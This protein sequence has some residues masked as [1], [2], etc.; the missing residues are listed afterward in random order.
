MMELR[1]HML[2]DFPKIVK[3]RIVGNCWN[4]ES[5][6]G[7]PDPKVP[8]SLCPRVPLLPRSLCFIP[9]MLLQIWVSVLSGGNVC[10]WASL[11][12]T[13]QVGPLN[14][15]ESWPNHP[16]LRQWLNQGV[17]KF[18]IPLFQWLPILWFLGEPTPSRPPAC[19]QSFSETLGL[20]GPLGFRFPSRSK[21]PPSSLCNHH[22]CR[23]SNEHSRLSAF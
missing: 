3:L 20:S 9:L 5:K 18:R 16:W 8:I 12:P 13:A 7:L 21:R 6:L 22:C 23:R 19:V 15:P 1:I 2:S 14:N 11:L 17:K 10:F 4:L